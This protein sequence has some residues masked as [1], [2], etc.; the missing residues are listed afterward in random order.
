MFFFMTI[1]FLVPFVKETIFFCLELSWCFFFFFKS[2]KCKIFLDS[3][4]FQ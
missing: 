4:L 3:V 2:S 1:Q